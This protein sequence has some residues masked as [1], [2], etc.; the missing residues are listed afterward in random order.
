[1]PSAAPAKG[2]KNYQRHQLHPQPILHPPPPPA[3]CTTPTPRRIVQLSPPSAAP[4]NSTTAAPV[5]EVDLPLSP[6]HTM[7]AQNVVVPEQV[8]SKRGHEVPKKVMW[9]TVVLIGISVGFVNFTMVIL[10]AKVLRLKFSYIQELL[11]N[12]GV[13]IAIP[14]FILVSCLCTF[15]ASTLTVFL[16]P[17]CA[18]SGLP[19]IKGYLNGN[20]M[21]GLF[22]LQRAWIRIF[23]IILVIAAGLPLGREGP[24]V[25]IG[26][27]CGLLILTKILKPYFKNWIRLAQDD[28]L[29]IVME[30]DNYHLIKRMGCTLGAAAGIAAAFNAP[31]GGCLYMFEETSGILNWTSFL[32]FGSFVCCGVAVLTNT[33]MMDVFGIDY[34]LVYQ[35]VLFSMP[36]HERIEREPW[37]W[38]DL[39]CISFLAVFTGSAAH[40][41]TKGALWVWRVRQLPWNVVR[42]G[43]LL[44]GALLLTKQALRKLKEVFVKMKTC[45]RRTKRSKSF[46]STTSPTLSIASSKQASEASC[47]SNASS[48]HP[49]SSAGVVS[50]HGVVPDLT[51]TRA[52]NEGYPLFSQAAGGPD[53]GEVQIEPVDPRLQAA[54][55]RKKENE[56]R[57][58]KNS[59]LWEKFLSRIK[60][61]FTATTK[62]ARTSS[63]S[64]R[65]ESKYLSNSSTT[66]TTKRRKNQVEHYSSDGDK[67]KERNAARC[68]VVVS[69]SAAIAPD[70]QQQQDQLFPIP[71]L[72]SKTDYG[73]STTEGEEEPDQHL[74][75]RFYNYASTT[76][77]EGDHEEG[78]YN[79]QHHHTISENKGETTSKP[80]IVRLEEV[81]VQKPSPGTS[82][83]TEHENDVDAVSEKKEGKDYSG[84]SV[85]AEEGLA[86]VHL[87]RKVL[88]QPQEQE[89]DPTIAAPASQQEPLQD[90]D[91]SPKKPTKTHWGKKVAQ[92]EIPDVTVCFETR[93]LCAKFGKIC[94]VVLVTAFILTIMGLAP[95]L[96]H[97]CEP[98]EELVLD[99]RR[100]W[101]AY[102]CEQEENTEYVDNL[103]AK[104][105]HTQGLISPD[106][107]LTYSPRRG[108]RMLG[109]GSEEN[110]LDPML[111]GQEPQESQPGATTRRTDSKTSN[112][113]ARQGG[114]SSRA[115]S[116][117]TTTLALANEF[118]QEQDPHREDVR[119]PE[120]DQ[121]YSE[122][123]PASRLLAETVV[124]H[125]NPMATMFLQ[126][127]EGAIKHLFARDYRFRPKRVLQQT[128][129]GQLELYAPTAGNE[130]SSSYHIPRNHRNHTFS[131]IEL[132][133]LVLSLV[134]YAP[135]AMLIPGLAMP[136]GMFI[137]NLFMGAV[138]GRIAGELVHMMD[139][140]P[141]RP[142]HPGFYAVAGAGAM[143][144]GFTHMSIAI[145]ALLVEAT[146]DMDMVI[147]ILVSIL[148][149]T[150]TNK[151][152]GGDNFDEHLIKLKKVPLL[153]P[154]LKLDSKTKNVGDVMEVF[155]ENSPQ[156]K[157]EDTKI[158]DIIQL[159]HNHPSLSHFVV[160]R[161]VNCGGLLAG[162][163]K[164]LGGGSACSY[165]AH[166]QLQQSSTAGVIGGAPLSSP[167]STSPN[168]GNKL[169]LENRGELVNTS[170]SADGA[171]VDKG[172][173]EAAT[174]HD[175]DKVVPRS[176][177]EDSTA[178]ALVEVTA[179]PGSVSAARPNR[180][181]SCPETELPIAGA[182]AADTS[183]GTGAVNAGYQSCAGNNGNGDHERKCS[184]SAATSSQ[185]Q[186]V[187]TTKSLTIDVKQTSESSAGEVQQTL[188]IPHPQQPCNPAQFQAVP[189]IAQQ[190]SQIYYN[191]VPPSTREK[192]N[193]L[194][195][196]CTNYEPNFDAMCT[197]YDGALS[198]A[199]GK[200]DNGTGSQSGQHSSSTHPHSYG[201]G[202]RPTAS[203]T[204][205]SVEIV[206]LI[207]RQRLEKVVSLHQDMLNV[208]QQC[209]TY[210]CQLTGQH[211]RLD[212]T[213]AQLAVGGEFVPVGGCAAAGAALAGGV[214]HHPM[215]GAHTTVVDIAQSNL[216]FV[217]NLNNT[218]NSP[219][220]PPLI[221]T[222]VHRLSQ[223]DFNPID[224]EDS[225]VLE[226]EDD[227]IEMHQQ[228]W[229]RTQSLTTASSDLLHALETN[230]GNNSTDMMLPH[231]PTSGTSNAGALL[232]GA[233]GSAFSPFSGAAAAAQGFF[234]SSTS[235]RQ[236]EDDMIPGLRNASSDATVFQRTLNMWKTRC[237]GGGSG[238]VVK[239][240]SSPVSRNSSAS[241]FMKQLAFG[242][243][244]SSVTSA[245]MVGNN[246][247]HNSG[248][249][250]NRGLVHNHPSSHQVPE[251]PR[252]SFTTTSFGST[253]T[254]PNLHNPVPTPGKNLH[255]GRGQ[256]GT[257]STTTRTQQQHHH[258]SSSFI[259]G[260]LQPGRSRSSI[261]GGK[262]GGSKN[263]KWMNKNAGSSSSTATSV[264]SNSPERNK[265]SV[266]VFGVPKNGNIFQSPFRI[267][268]LA[269]S[270]KASK[271]TAAPR[272]QQGTNLHAT[273]RRNRL[274]TTRAEDLDLNSEAHDAGRAEK[275]SAEITNRQHKN[276]GKLSHGTRTTTRDEDVGDHHRRS[277][278]VALSAKGTSGDETFIPVGDDDSLGEE[279]DDAGILS[280]DQRKRRKNRRTSMPCSPVFRHGKKFAHPLSFFFSSSSGSTANGANKH[281]PTIS[282]EVGAGSSGSRSGVLGGGTTTAKGN[283][284]GASREPTSSSSSNNVLH[285]DRT[286]KNRNK[287]SVRRGNDFD[288]HENQ[289][290]D[291]KH[292]SGS[293]VDHYE[294]SR[295]EQSSPAPPVVPGR[296]IRSSNGSWIRE[297][298]VDPNRDLVGE[299]SVV[300]EA[301]A[302]KGKTLTGRRENDERHLLQDHL[303]VEDSSLAPGADHVAPSS[304]NSNFKNPNRFHQDHQTN[305][306]DVETHNFVGDTDEGEGAKQLEA[307]VQKKLL[308]SRSFPSALRHRHLLPKWKWSH[309]FGEP[310]PHQR[311]N[312][313]GQRR[314]R[315]SIRNSRHRG[316]S[317]LST[318]SSVATNVAAATVSGEASAAEATQEADPS[319]PPEMRMSAQQDRVETVKTVVPSNSR[320]STRPDEAEQEGRGG[321]RNKTNFGQKESDD[322]EEI[323]P[324]KMQVVASIVVAPASTTAVECCNK[325]HER[326][327]QER[328]RDV[329]RDVDTTSKPLPREEANPDGAQRAG[330]PGEIKDTVQLPEEDHQ[331]SPSC[332]P[333]P[334]GAQPAT[335][336]R[337]QQP[338]KDLPVQQ[339]VERNEANDP[340]EDNSKLLDTISLWNLIDPAPYCVG[341]DFP[342]QRIYPLFISAHPVPAVVV[343]ERGRLRGVL[344]RRHL[345][346]LSHE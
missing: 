159:L 88:H 314:R 134:I 253:I 311:S 274:P 30:E 210:G 166:Q 193:L 69:T 95:L 99:H 272:L 115:P 315:R 36:E 13:I 162:S 246:S 177:S 300:P 125:F 201:G 317:S 251:P 279:G 140:L 344:T 248:Q 218:I 273:D 299:R 204:A 206:G 280:P 345:T 298:I 174:S 28:E 118:Y 244:S 33:F 301:G 80:V 39:V 266:T 254:N 261:L 309:H 288:A 324:D 29:T 113:L 86:D 267:R 160:L 17:L 121:D 90:A 312:S 51:G 61:K 228:Q 232:A 195:T 229:Q 170:T 109:D 35:L 197:N 342:I 180:T 326:G 189:N 96:S 178:P 207:S 142:A 65:V 114:P 247:N 156:L 293:G 171:K 262:F 234:S 79:Q 48:T 84:T 255:A 77:E 67:E 75:H 127:E 40:F 18:G 6:P 223:A 322:D 143:L 222:R 131:Y 97:K 111:G 292:L 214:D 296:W 337:Q 237:V 94:E 259:P 286:N 265:T 149:A 212:G 341:P 268:N 7:N 264:T 158:C 133:W 124:T 235:R 287:I 152:L 190:T 24:M 5:G 249:G 26:G 138:L 240:S 62:R 163:G 252:R 220:L 52:T 224:E 50:N 148:F 23:G 110:N 164:F 346:H 103:R 87:E 49:S 161:N 19:E 157:T 256:L 64:R 68:V 333:P 91:A 176:T 34:R 9:L 278:R 104:Q 290:H 343:Y 123:E 155:A 167:V 182:L 32:T 277:D 284:D 20:P 128:S 46:N 44:V 340:E 82:A 332:A 73:A 78:K 16:A 112:L 211:N 1:M 42:S 15:V 100:H 302:S 239:S 8:P 270:S 230:W 81:T 43:R 141:F 76:D 12:E 194:T 258:S 102:T 216:E 306:G 83:C 132:Q 11:W 47:I 63:D 181:D 179:A 334:V 10:D 319:S 2:D 71:K 38:P 22:V 146:H 60:T 186:H 37:D 208:W 53:P 59:S 55:R 25:C 21:P 3:I 4:G 236:S 129:T 241:A 331:W 325:D 231:L 238:G 233:G 215:Q 285:L 203:P 330:Q 281:S 144:S 168:V 108:R 316:H 209:Q 269:K 153:Y 275:V 200:N 56:Y 122:S 305:P 198:C 310:H 227:F 14:I 202:P 329:G 304:S 89:D 336:Q 70:K 41:F 106:I 187:L 307:F 320:R 172:C 66:T 303:D 250:Q 260:L 283:N 225:L 321:A 295:S 31:I 72:P 327:F 213:T 165:N 105:E 139:F 243:G 126:G 226:E 116:S 335:Q 291:G 328:T 257:N 323:D 245:G 27:S 98:V 184:S 263:S 313:R 242:A 338:A 107:D 221:N 85:V 318:S 137:P 308:R 294:H 150:L 188:A 271:T 74:D 276:R 289:Q 119:A 92:N 339:S 45:Y 192:K 136:F 120:V 151:Y 191:P 219:S 135:L 199:N 145:V 173:Q 147:P 57:K 196:T 154:E 169:G 175:E 297:Q 185:Q 101:A 54:T 93:L 205:S 183:G 282:Q 217:Q 117:T 58:M 130:P